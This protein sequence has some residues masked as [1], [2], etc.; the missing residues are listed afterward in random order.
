MTDK[1]HDNCCVCQAIRKA[2]AD[3][4]KLTLQE[5]VEA[6]KNERERQA[7]MVFGNGFTVT[8]TRVQ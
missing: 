3:G 8:Q 1:F 4:R 7:S 2:E 5:C 6:M